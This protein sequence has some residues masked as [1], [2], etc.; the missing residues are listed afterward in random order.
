MAIINAK[1]ISKKEKIKVE[2]NK[3]IYSEIQ[4]YC[5]WVGIDDLNHFFEEAASFVFSKDKDW[6]SFKKSSRSSQR[7]QKETS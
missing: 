7:A 4:S 6:K 3:S 1:S 2:L 5:S